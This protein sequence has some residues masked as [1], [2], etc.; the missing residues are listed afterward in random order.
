MNKEGNLYVMDSGNSQVQKFDSEGNFL[1]AWGEKGTGNGQFNI[2]SHGGGRIAVDEAGNVYV[3]DSSYRIQKFDSNGTFLLQ[4]GGKGSGDAE[5]YLPVDVAVDMNGNIYTVEVLNGRVQKFNGNGEVIS[6][7][8]IPEID[9]KLV[10][11]GDIEVDVQGNIYITDWSNMR[12]V[13][14]D[15]NGNPLGV[16]GEPGTEDSQFNEPWCV[17]LDGQGNIYVADSVNS[18]IQKFQLK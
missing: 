8:F 15:N 12:V 1:L 9:D 13:K 17:A 7:F 3:G 2:N 6:K 18:R 4:W 11:P 14:L 5:L 16:W 10:T